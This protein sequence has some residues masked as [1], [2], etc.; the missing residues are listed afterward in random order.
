VLYVG[1]YLN[2]AV[3]EAIIPELVKLAG[4]APA[5]ARIPAEVEVVRRESAD[6]VLWFVINHAEESRAV[7]VPAGRDLVSD[8][9]VSGELSLP[10]R[11][12]AVIQENRGL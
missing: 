1:T 6:R 3:G 11:G 9:T 5:L 10:A 8:R 7:A 4:L 2:G 12:V